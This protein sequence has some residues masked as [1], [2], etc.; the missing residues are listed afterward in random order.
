MKPFTDTLEQNKKHLLPLLFKFVVTVKLLIH[1]FIPKQTTADAA[2][3]GSIKYI[4]F[5]VPLGIFQE[6][7]GN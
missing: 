6:R 5:S 3:T 7:A 4:T 2:A 1:L